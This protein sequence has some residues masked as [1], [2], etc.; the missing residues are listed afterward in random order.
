MT[1]NTDKLQKSKEKN[2]LIDGSELIDRLKLQN[3]NFL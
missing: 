1:S 3:I 2:R